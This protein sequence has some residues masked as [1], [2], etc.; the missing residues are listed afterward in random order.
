[1][2]PDGTV[3]PGSRPLSKRE[4]KPSWVKQQQIEQEKMEK[5]VE[6]E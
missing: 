5:G 6:D 1:M 3:S 2:A 4:K